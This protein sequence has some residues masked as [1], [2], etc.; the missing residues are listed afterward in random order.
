MFRRNKIFASCACI[1]LRCMAS[2]TEMGTI[3][4]KNKKK[5]SVVSAPV[6]TA[7]LKNWP[8]RLSCTMRRAKSE[9]G[10][11]TPTYVFSTPLH[12]K[13]AGP[14]TLGLKCFH[15][16]MVGYTEYYTY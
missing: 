10:H 15:K 3:F 11:K 14:E 7:V 6:Y 13:D 1:V 8:E 9:K 12:R 16:L 2:S 4:N 5:K